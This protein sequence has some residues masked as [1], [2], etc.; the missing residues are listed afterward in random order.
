MSTTAVAPA[1]I[2][3]AITTQTLAY[4]PAVL[5]G[6]QVAEQSNASG[7]TKQQAVINAVLAGSQ[8]LESA[9]NPNVAGI[10][11]LVNLFVAILNATG[12]LNHKAKTGA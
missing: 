12:A 9:P 2:V 6:I 10:A 1:P 3:T 7:A 8:S 5:A 11:A 4:A